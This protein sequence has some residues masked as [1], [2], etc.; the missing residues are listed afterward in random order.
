MLQILKKHDMHIVHYVSS[1][2]TF[3]KTIQHYDKA[4]FTYKTKQLQRIKMSFYIS[5][6]VRKL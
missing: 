6:H 2:C 4:Q 1:M 5:F 3:W